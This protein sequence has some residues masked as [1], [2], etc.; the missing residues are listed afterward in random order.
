MSKF[1]FS[2]FTA[3]FFIFVFSFSFGVQ[4]QSRADYAVINQA[5]RISGDKF[6]FVFMCNL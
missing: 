2:I 4:A 5:E 1:R 6:G 3:L